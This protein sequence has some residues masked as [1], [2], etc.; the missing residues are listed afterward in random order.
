MTASGFAGL[1]WK[2]AGSSA[3]GSMVDGTGTD[4]GTFQL[5][6]ITT[7]IGRTANIQMQALLFSP[8]TASITASF[9][10]LLPATTNVA[11]RLG[12]MD[13]ALAGTADAAYGVYFEFNTAVYGTTLQGRTASNSVRTAVALQTLTANTFV[14]LKLT[15]NATNAV[16]YVNN[17]QK[18]ATTLNLPVTSAAKLTCAMGLVNVVSALQSVQIDT[19]MHRLQ[20]YSGRL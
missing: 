14:W 13:G 9:R 19:W 20:F 6:T 3:A 1:S 17:I 15:L 10:I 12:F 5:A 7:N 8:S 2:I 11:L 16:F 4:V 18:G